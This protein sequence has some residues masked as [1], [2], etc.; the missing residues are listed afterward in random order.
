MLL[1]GHKSRTIFDRDNIIHEQE[2]LDAGDQLVAYL[3]Q[4]A[5]ALPRGRA[6][7]DRRRCHA[8][9]AAPPPRATHHRVRARGRGASGETGLNMIVRDRD[10]AQQERVRERLRDVREALACAC[11]A[12]KRPISGWS[13]R[14]RTVIPIARWSSTATASPSR[15]CRHPPPT[16][17]ARRRRPSRGRTGRGSS[18]QSYQRGAARPTAG[19]ESVRAWEPGSGVCGASGRRGCRILRRAPAATGLEPRADP[20]RVDVSGDG[21]QRF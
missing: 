1:I 3:A 10:V 17:A 21:C 4:Q 9:R 19:V 15:P 6:T 20:G 14:W 18:P 7:P 11:A 8:H 12:S 16:G 5:Q 13:R 2:L